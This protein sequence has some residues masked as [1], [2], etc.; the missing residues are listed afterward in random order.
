MSLKGK[1]DY[2]NKKNSK[3]PCMAIKL[4]LEKAFSRMEWNRTPFPFF[5]PSLVER[6]GSD[7]LFT[8]SEIKWQRRS[9]CRENRRN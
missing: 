2:F 3:T 7:S 5:A 8:R 9:Q 1:A 6:L 4:D